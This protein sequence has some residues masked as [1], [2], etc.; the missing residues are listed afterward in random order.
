MVVDHIAEFVPGTPIWMH[1]IGRLASPLFILL[2]CWSCEFT[3]DRK[4]YLTRLYCAGVLMSLIQGILGIDNNI[5]TCLFQ[6]ALII[7]LLSANTMKHKI[8]NITAYLSYQIIVGALLWLIA[9]YSPDAILRII[10][11][12]FGSAIGVEGGIF[13]VV[14]GVALWAVKDSPIALSAAFVGLNALLSLAFS[15]IGAQI[16]WYAQHAS[17]YVLGPQGPNIVNSLLDM[18]G[19]SMFSMGQS[20]LTMNYQWM[21]IFA[22]PFMLLYNKRRGRNVKWFFYAFYPSHIVILYCIGQAMRLL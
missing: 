10:V 11:A 1:W 2:V 7:V 6:I 19:I 21:M 22:L 20:P 15:S 9:P 14:L 8:R 12:V 5:F 17:L 4:R 18:F 13:Y 3:G 16:T